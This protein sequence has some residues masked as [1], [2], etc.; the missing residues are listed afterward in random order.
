MRRLLFLVA[1]SV[2]IVSFTGCKRSDL[3]GVSTTV[4]DVSTEST[5]AEMT[6]PA[7]A[8]DL[9]VD[10]LVKLY[11]DAI[12]NADSVTRIYSHAEYK[13]FSLSAE[14][15]E[16]TAKTVLDSTIKNNDVEFTTVKK[17][18]IEEILPE[19]CLDKSEIKK[20][21]NSDGKITLHLYDE[22]NPEDEGCIKLYPADFLSDMLGQYNISVDNVNMLYT[23]GRITFTVDDNKKVTDLSYSWNVNARGNFELFFN[24]QSFGIDICV[25][26]SFKF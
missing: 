25:E 9:S 13:N 24:T 8:T 16:S 4:P 12:K 17:S 1:L 5:S 2:L 14:A 23:D 15:F 22:E 21:E 20:Y 19:P 26:E 6:A 7:A 3:P 11:N 10:E 18:E